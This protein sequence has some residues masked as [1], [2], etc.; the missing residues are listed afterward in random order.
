MN[1]LWYISYFSCDQENWYVKLNTLHLIPIILFY[2]LMARYLQLI[3]MCHKKV[4]LIQTSRKDWDIWTEFDILASELIGAAK[5]TCAPSKT[6]KRVS[7]FIMPP[8][9][10]SGFHRTSFR[11]MAC[12]V[13]RPI[14]LKVEDVRLQNVSMDTLVSGSRR[15]VLEQSF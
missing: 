6:R 5:L 8:F 13:S 2:H 14:Q 9:F 1:T 11:K 3:W 7:H 4:K 10:Q 12:T 15:N